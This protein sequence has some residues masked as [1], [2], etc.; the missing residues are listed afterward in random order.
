VPIIKQ[1]WE[2]YMDKKYFEIILNNGIV[3]Y[4][5]YLATGTLCGEF[6]KDDVAGSAF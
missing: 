5:K 6:N 4:Q 1:K 2:V 3:T